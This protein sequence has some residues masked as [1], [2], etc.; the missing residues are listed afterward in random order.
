L[1]RVRSG[2]D[3]EREPGNGDAQDQLPK[4]REGNSNAISHVTW[5]IIQRKA[6]PLVR[7]D[8]S[9]PFWLAPSSGLSRSATAF[10]SRI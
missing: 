5:P 4:K 6:S 8:Q 2:M 9:G 10:I 7:F 1:F 3:D